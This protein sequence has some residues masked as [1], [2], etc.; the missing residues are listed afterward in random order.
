MDTSR[1]DGIIDPTQLRQFGVTV[2]GAGAVGS[3]AI[4]ALTKM[5]VENIKVYDEDGVTAHNIPNQFYRLKD[6]SGAAFKVEALAEIVKE[7]TGV[8]MQYETGMY[9]NQELSD[10]VV[11]ATDSMSSRK[12]VWEQFKQQSQ[13]KY[14]VEARMGGELGRIYSIGRQKFANGMLDLGMLTLGEDD[15]KFY[16]DTLYTDDEAA[17]LRCSERAIIY[18]VL[19][20]AAFICRSVKGFV[21]GETVKR[22]M[23]FNFA[24]MEEDSLVYMGRS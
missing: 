11:V 9:H 3:Y 19:M 14:L 21:R 7:F 1:Q 17:Q 18:N 23:I 22:E 5:G 15:I 20:I 13:C 2:I 10:I 12:L 16:E 4:Q 24:Q 8:N 6:A